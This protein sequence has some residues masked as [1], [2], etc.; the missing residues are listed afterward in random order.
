MR[1]NNSR[2]RKAD[3]RC[4]CPIRQTHFL[5]IV[6]KYKYTNTNVN[7]QL[8]LPSFAHQSVPL[9]LFA[10]CL[11]RLFTR[12]SDI[13][14]LLFE[15]EIKFSN[16]NYLCPFSQEP[17]QQLNSTKHLKSLLIPIFNFWFAEC[18]QK[19]IKFE[20]SGTPSLYKN[21]LDPK[22]CF[23]GITHFSQRR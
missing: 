17:W 15:L 21:K 5:V 11:N 13:L 6:I 7:N 16:S 20:V 2:G 9:R 8:R 18:P 22:K 14:S 12:C 23:V 4:H 3:R 19:V 10:I 1:T